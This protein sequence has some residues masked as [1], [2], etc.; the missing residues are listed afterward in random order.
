MGEQHWTESGK[1][2]PH[3]PIALVRYRN[4]EQLEDDLNEIALTQGNR[5]TCTDPIIREG[6]FGYTAIYSLTPAQE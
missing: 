4:I 3:R 5:W 1:Y 2:G 6:E